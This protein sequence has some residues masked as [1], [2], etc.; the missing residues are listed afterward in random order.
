M[1][2]FLWPSRAAFQSAIPFQKIDHTMA[3]IKKSP[4]PT[5]TNQKGDAHGDDERFCKLAMILF[6][7]PT[8]RGATTIVKV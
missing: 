6:S 5:P 7:V 3:R 2:H 8:F 1:N 4:K